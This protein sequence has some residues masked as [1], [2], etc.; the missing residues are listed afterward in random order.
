M[1]TTRTRLI[2]EGLSMRLTQVRQVKKKRASLPVFDGKTGLVNG[3]KGLSNREYL[4]AL[5]R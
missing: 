5:G 4:D 3:L 2:Q 1:K